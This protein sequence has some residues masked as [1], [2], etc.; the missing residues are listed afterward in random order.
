MSQETLP[1][2]KLP[3]GVYVVALL[4]LLAPLANIVVSFA[5][6]GMANWY[7]PA[8][9]LALVKTI[10]AP[11]AVWL[12]G[13]FVSGVALL[14]R[15]KSAWSLAVASLVL[16]L[17][18][19]AYRAL[20]LD[21]LSPNLDL[22]HAQIAFSVGVTLSL[23]IIGFYARYPYLDRRQQWTFPTA[24]RYDVKTAVIVH[25]GGDLAGLTESISSAGLFIRLATPTDVLADKTE[26]VISL[27]DLLQLKAIAADIVQFDRDA[28]R[29][30]FKKFGWGARGILEAWLRS[31]TPPR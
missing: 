21:A 14:L 23:L 8:E 15:H 13:T 22:V 10:P 11:D 25:T 27:T 18:F 12:A 9:F 20:R 1:N 6:S 26:V 28:L 29:L 31:K 2:L 17:L 7:H 4:F 16:V 19:N 24:H 30:R 3:I 5:Y